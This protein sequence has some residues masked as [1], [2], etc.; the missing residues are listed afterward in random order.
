MI[1]LPEPAGS[2]IPPKKVSK[3]SN[4]SESV[5]KAMNKELLK[6]TQ[7]LESELEAKNQESAESQSMIIKL[8]QSLQSKVATLSLAQRGEKKQKD[9]LQ[10]AKE[11]IKELE[12]KLESQN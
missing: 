7:S 11:K 6:K 2:I 10:K 9:E 1:L 4:M 5:E 3:K 12:A 8:Q